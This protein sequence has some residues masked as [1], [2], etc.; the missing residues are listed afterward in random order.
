MI[1]LAASLGFQTCGSM[2]FRGCQIRKS[3]YNGEWDVRCLGGRLCMNEVNE[4]RSKGSGERI[5]EI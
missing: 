2:D 5:M 4:R 1:V 3:M